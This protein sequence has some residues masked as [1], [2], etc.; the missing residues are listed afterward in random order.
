MQ[1]EPWFLGG[2]GQGLKDWWEKEK[3]HWNERFYFLNLP[4]TKMEAWSLAMITKAH[5]THMWP[6]PQV[7][8]S[9]TLWLKSQQLFEIPVQDDPDKVDLE[10]QK[11]LPPKKI[12]VLTQP[13]TIWCWHWLGVGWPIPWLAKDHPGFETKTPMSREPSQS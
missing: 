8:K 9:Q 2:D 11:R 1:I 6:S 4:L 5:D 7:I 3:V 12:K 10:C 13:Y